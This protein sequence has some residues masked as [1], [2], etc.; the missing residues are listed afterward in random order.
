MTDE[1]YSQIKVQ[2][3]NTNTQTNVRV[4]KA[5][6]TLAGGA[7]R[8]GVKDT[9]NELTAKEINDLNNDGVPTIQTVYPGKGAYYINPNIKNGITCRLGDPNCYIMTSF[10]PINRTGQNLYNTTIWTGNNY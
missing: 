5:S 4:D 3:Y 8:R 1:P 9:G 7:Q 6:L 10:N 2:F